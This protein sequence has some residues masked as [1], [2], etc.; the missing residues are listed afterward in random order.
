MYRISLSTRFVFYMSGG[1]DL[2][3]GKDNCK[4]EI[5]VV[6]L[7]FAGKVMAVFYSLF[8]R[9]FFEVFETRRFET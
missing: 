4:T 7:M 2:Y 3:K 6:N 1:G 8:Y 5:N 9:G